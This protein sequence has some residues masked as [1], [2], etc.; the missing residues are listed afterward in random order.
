MGYTVDKDQKGVVKGKTRYRFDCRLNGKRLRKKVQC[1]PS[2]VVALYRQWEREQETLTPKVKNYKLFEIID[3]YLAY[4]DERKHKAYVKVHR[5]EMMLF[6]EFIGNLPVNEIRRYHIKDYKYWRKQHSLAP[7]KQE[8]SSRAVN[9]SI[10]V[11]SVVF[12]Y[13][14]DR[15]IYVRANPASR[16]KDPEDNYRLVIL[17][18]DQIAELFDKAKCK[19]NWLF[20]GMVLTLFAGLRKQEI[21]ELKWGDCDWINGVIN[22]R[23]SATKSKKQRTVPVPNFLE[24]HLSEFQREGEWILMDKGKKVKKDKF[25]YHFERLR[26]SLSFAKLPNGL[27]LTFHDLRHVYAQSLRDAGVGL[28][29]IQAYMGH[30]SVELTVRRYAQRGGVDGKAKVNKLSEVYNIH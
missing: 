15:E 9:F 7:H 30:S 3:Q 11:L 26:D 17:T 22:L 19:S 1:Y 27:T 25:W 28:G 20:L 8:V 24:K 14:I 6:K 2:Q 13:M 4:I 29:D 5:K 10:S 16:C 18:P 21:V 23:S 12:N